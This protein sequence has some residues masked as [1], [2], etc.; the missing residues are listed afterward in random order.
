MKRK[1][2]ALFLTVLLSFSVF[3]PN[4]ALNDNV[5]CRIEEEMDED[6]V[7]LDGQKISLTELMKMSLGQKKIKFRLWEIICELCR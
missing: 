7:M 2:A 5:L 3:Y 6:T 1:I 4:L